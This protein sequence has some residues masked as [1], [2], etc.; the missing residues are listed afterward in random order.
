MIYIYIFYNYNI[1]RASVIHFNWKD[2]YAVKVISQS[3]L[4]SDCLAPG[5]HL[6]ITHLWKDN[7]FVP[8][9]STMPIWDLLPW[10]HQRSG[11][12]LLVSIVVI[13]PLIAA[14]AQLMAV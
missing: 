5:L 11:K 10:W 12:T 7:T 14:A 9:F 3:A 8:P 1:Y 6:I 2:L 13:L 4:L